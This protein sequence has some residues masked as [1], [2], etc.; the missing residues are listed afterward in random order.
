MRFYFLDEGGAILKTGG[1]D[2]LAIADP[3][4][5]PYGAAAMEVLRSLGVDTALK[6]LEHAYD[7]IGPNW[8]KNATAPVS[9]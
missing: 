1:F 4:L 5:A 6:P 8:K 9:S 2:R 7:D 3:K